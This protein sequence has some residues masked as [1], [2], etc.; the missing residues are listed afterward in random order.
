MD[1]AEAAVEALADFI[2]EYSLPTKLSQLR[3]KMEITPE[4]LGR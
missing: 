4:L 3:S 1:G 2:K